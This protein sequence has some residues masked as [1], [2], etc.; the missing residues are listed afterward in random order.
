MRGP[1]ALLSESSC[2]CS[3]PAAAFKTRA[4][5]AKAVVRSGADAG[6]RKIATFRAWDASGRLFGGLGWRL[7]SCAS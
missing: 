5:A 4:D 7:E 1:E 3:I 2:V 6:M